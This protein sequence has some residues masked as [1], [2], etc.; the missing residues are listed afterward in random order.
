MVMPYR[1]IIDTMMGFDRDRSPWLQSE[2]SIDLEVHPCLHIEEDPDQGQGQN[3]SDRLNP[4]AKKISVEIERDATKKL[5]AVFEGKW[6]VAGPSGPRLRALKL[7]L[8]WIAL[9]YSWH[10]RWQRAF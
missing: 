2:K 9:S 3:Q 5:I 1:T 7:V 8:C 10:L 6:A 4:G